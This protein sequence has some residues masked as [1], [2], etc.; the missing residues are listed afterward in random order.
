[1]DGLC[2]GDGAYYAD[3]GDRSVVASGNSRF[4]YSCSSGP[5]TKTAANLRIIQ[6]GLMPLGLRSTTSVSFNGYMSLISALRHPRE[7][8]SAEIVS[9]E[10][11]MHSWG[12]KKAG[13]AAEGIGSSYE[14]RCT[15]EIKITDGISRKC[16]EP[17]SDTKSISRRIDIKRDVA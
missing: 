1:M 7:T 13:S 2:L 11:G 16:E 4:G 8:K 6:I 9:Q 14:I 12:S 15:Y 10:C 5:A 17:D 3:C